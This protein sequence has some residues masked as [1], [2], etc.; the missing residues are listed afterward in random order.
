MMKN[1][2]EHF[3]FYP[4]FCKR[5]QLRSLVKT[6]DEP[7]PQCKKS[8]QVRSSCKDKIKTEIKQQLH[9]TDK[10]FN[11][12]LNKLVNELDTLRVLVKYQTFD[13]EATRRENKY[14]RNLLENEAN[15]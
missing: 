10:Q 13:L 12:I 11:D 14:L 4:I 5:C 7:C 3:I 1:S 9:K 15:E 8:D 6:L 2:N